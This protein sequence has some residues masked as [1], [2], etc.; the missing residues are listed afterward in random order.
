MD[1]FKISSD[2]FV[3]WLANDVNVKISP[4][5]E[6]ADFRDLNQG[7]CVM[8]TDD[9]AL[10]EVLFEIPRESILNIETC[11]LSKK[12][13]E[14]KERLY[15]GVGHW[16]GLILVLLYELRVCGK[17]SRWWPYFEVFPTKENMNGLMYWNDEELKHLEPSLVLQ[18]IGK[19]SAEEMFETVKELIQDFGIQDE[20]MKSITW[21]DFVFVASVIMSYSFDVEDYE[22]EE[23]DDDEENDDDDDALVEIVHGGE[24]PS[25]RDDK[26]LKSMIPLAD[27]LNADTKKCNANLMYDEHS[28]K[29]H[30]IKPIAKGEQVYNLYGEHPNSEILRRY[31]YVEEDGS[32]Y[33]FGEVP[34]ATIDKVLQT[35]FSQINKV[36]DL[37]VQVYDAIRTD[38]T[39]QE[40]LEF[41]DIVVDSCECYVDGEVPSE[42][43]LL[44]QIVVVLLQ[45]PNIGTFTP[46]EV[47]R[48][49]QRVSKKCFQLLGSG[50]ITKRCD[51]I[52][53]LCIIERLKDY[54]VDPN[55]DIQ[56]LHTT[57]NISELR[58]VMADVMLKCE[59]ASLT[60]CKDAFNAKFKLIE[61]Q[62]LLNNILK[63]KVEEEA[64]EP[65]KK[66]IRKNKK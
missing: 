15:D 57:R 24:S 54:N 28:L 45:I 40:N 43:A 5:I 20:S 7:R 30:A 59:V 13:P 35:E 17:E 14:A 37:L 11:E 53:K 63:R 12:Y 32:K 27:T 10:D 50:K 29:M 55:L 22:E 56:K 3:H 8:A 1:N 49:V 47:I 18:R 51:E 9:I 36:D 66:R 48:Y 33:D 64:P 23:E 16:E 58:H 4:K 39:V 65:K 21:D 6:V 44:L 26:S 31:G 34:L 46:E 52:W 41:E 25:V 62:K 2:S 38:D 42:C 19:D 61:D 60:A